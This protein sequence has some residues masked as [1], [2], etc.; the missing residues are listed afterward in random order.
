MDRRILSQL[1]GSSEFI[2]PGSGTT[3]VRRS[4]TIRTE[5]LRTIRRVL[6]PR[7]EVISNT[8]AVRRSLRFRCESLRTLLVTASIPSESILSGDVVV[9]PYS[10]RVRVR[11]NKDLRI[12][13]RV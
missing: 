7:S 6:T 1:Q 11:W 12:K 10:T 9:I 13:L 5:S 3:E 8:F 4:L 2:F